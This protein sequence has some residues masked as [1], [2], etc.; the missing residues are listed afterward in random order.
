[1]YGQCLITP[2]ILDS[3]EFA[4]SAPSSWKARAEEGFLAKLRREKATYPAWVSKGLDFEDTV[5]RVCGVHYKDRFKD[6]PV[7]QG[8]EL[9]QNVCAQCIGGTFQQKLSKKADIA[10]QK[11]FFFGYTDVSFPTITIDLKT[12]LKYKGPSKYLN[13]HQHLI[14]SWIRGVKEFQYIVV[15]WASE[16][17]NTVQAVHNIDYT[18]PDPNKLEEQIR[19]KVESFF[20]YLRNNNLWLDYYNTFSKN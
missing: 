16:D 15:Q 5:Y 6:N 4:I 9:F 12:T 18:A 13:G 17:A 14:Y 7:K 20:D 1:M 11:V 19:G 10:G 8:S 2:T 3:Y